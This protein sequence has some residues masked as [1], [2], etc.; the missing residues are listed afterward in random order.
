MQF[1]DEADVVGVI[2]EFNLVN[3]PVPSGDFELAVP[4]RFLG[5]HSLDVAETVATEGGYLTRFGIFGRATSVFVDEDSGRVLSGVDPNAVEIVNTSLSRFIE[6]V[7][8]L[9]TMA[10]FY[11]E[12]SDPDEWENAALRVE[13]VIRRIDPSAYGESSFWYEFRWDVTMGDFHE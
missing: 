12:D 13:E 10:P 4:D 9:T 2:V 8:D 11:S 6:C 5:Y 3:V 1:Q 7:R